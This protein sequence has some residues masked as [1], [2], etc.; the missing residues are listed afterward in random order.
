MSGI[1]KAVQQVSFALSKTGISKERK[2]S[3]QSYMYRGIDDYLNALSPLL[4]KHGIVI[5]PKYSS[6]EST[7]VAKTAKGNAILQARVIGEF[8][9]VSVE[10]GSTL[11]AVVPGE[12]RDSADKAVN[13][14]LSAAYKYM[15][16]QVFCIPFIGFE[17][18]EAEVGQPE[19]PSV[20]DERV[21]TWKDAITATDTMEACKAAYENAIAEVGHDEQAS[22]A[23]FAHTK[24]H[25][26]ALKAKA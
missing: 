1:L 5:C 12:G 20:S 10:D 25:R 4:A 6:V 7:E 13:K 2:N 11:V 21:Q 19:R 17:D 16:A 8:T 14:A 24:A 3:E 15:A 23:I 9:L 22:A 26:A 18:A